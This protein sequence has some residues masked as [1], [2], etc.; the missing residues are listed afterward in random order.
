MTEVA[1]K[2]PE[3]DYPPAAAPTIFT[4]SVLNVARNENV[5]KFYLGRSDPD[6][7]NDGRS[8]VVIVGQVVMGFKTFMQTAVFFESVLDNMVREKV[9]TQQEIDNLRKQFNKAS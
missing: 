2:I 7:L 1:A 8:K 6:A 5:V 9:V 3:P 4:D